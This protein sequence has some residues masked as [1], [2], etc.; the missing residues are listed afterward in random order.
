MDAALSVGSPSTRWSS[1][2]GT[3]IC[4]IHSGKRSFFPRSPLGSFPELY[5][6]HSVLVVHVDLLQ[7]CLFDRA[8]QKF[9]KHRLMKKQQRKLC[10]YRLLWCIF[11]WIQ[12]HLQGPLICMRAIR[13]PSEAARSASTLP[14]SSPRCTSS[15]RTSPVCAGKSSLLLQRCTV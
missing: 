15:H 14:A 1:T 11:K 4:G 13:P 12:S 6:S 3:R 10:I 8:K 5:V 7:S 2:Q 9:N